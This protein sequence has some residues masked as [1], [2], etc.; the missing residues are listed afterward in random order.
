M[1]DVD[2]A[3]L[4]EEAT[5]DVGAR[6]VS[7]EVMAEVLHRLG[8]RGVMA[9]AGVSRGWRDCAAPALPRALPPP[10]PDGK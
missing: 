3:E 6:A 1:E 2:E 4:D 8:P 5:V 7:R 10:P 9:A